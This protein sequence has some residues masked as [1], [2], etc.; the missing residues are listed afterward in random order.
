MKIVLAAAIA[1]CSACSLIA[2]GTDALTQEMLTKWR[3][4]RKKPL[5]EPLPSGAVSDLQRLAVRGDD[6]ART[7]LVQAGHE[8]TIRQCLADL[9][10][11]RGIRRRAARALQ[12]SGRADIIA[13]LGDDLNLNE[14]TKPVSVP[15]GL[16]VE[17][18]SAISMYVCDIISGILVAS[19]PFP[20]PVKR[21]AENLKV[22]AKYDRDAIREQMRV[23]WKENQQLIREGRYEDVKPPSRM[24]ATAKP[25][26]TITPTASPSQ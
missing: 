11:E 3:M 25:P 5:E 10:N 18:T 20:E 6:D 26:S 7:L 8:E 15:H 24:P 4:G 9:H 17:K 22:S 12:G 1:L 14:S 2:Q 21:W 23:W 13:R 16:E 19:P